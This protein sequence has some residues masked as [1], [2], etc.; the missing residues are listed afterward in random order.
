MGHPAVQSLLPAQATEPTA[1]LSAAGS[2]RFTH[3]FSRIPLHS[4]GAGVLQTKLAVNAPGDEYEQEADH[5]S[6]QVMRLPEPSPRVGAE[7]QQHKPGQEHQ[8]LQTKRVDGSDLGQTEAPPLVHEVLRSPGQPLD[9]ATRAFMEPRFGHDFSQVRVHTDSSA[10]QSAREV[11]AKAYTVGH[12]VVFGPGQFAPGT[13]EGQRLIAHEFAHVIQQDRGG[14]A[15]SS[16]AG[17]G[18]LEQAA[19]RAAAQAVDG[20]KTVAVAGAA[21]PSLMCDPDDPRSKRAHFDD[22]E[23]DPSPRQKD[24]DKTKKRQQDRANAGKDESQIDQAEAERELR[25]LEASYQA[26]GAKARSL[27]TKEEDL[28]RFERLLARAGGTQLQKNQRKG[29]F[30]AN[31][32]AAR[33][34]RPPAAR[35]PSK[36]AVAR[37][38]RIRSFAPARTRMRNRTTRLNGGSRT[39]P[40]NGSMSI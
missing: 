20:S 19:D 24:K 4:P 36:S 17:H 30:D 28:K 22:E 23:N 7:D 25:K 16:V 33:R 31:C 26:P 13:Q 2:P 9:A 29:A 40:S 34:A 35:R 21:A 32:L 1:G 14:A 39:A 10:G 37:N 15:V 38:C 5:V 8:R 3:D 27:K 12:H 11:K 18:P 6:A